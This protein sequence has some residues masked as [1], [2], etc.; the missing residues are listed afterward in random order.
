[1]LEAHILDYAGDLYGKTMLVEFLQKIR[2]DRRFI[3]VKELSA[4][5]ARDVEQARIFFRK[6]SRH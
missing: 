5:I 4:Q 3:D 1:V 2:D 6:R